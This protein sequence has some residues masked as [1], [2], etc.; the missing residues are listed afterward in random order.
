MYCFNLF[1]ALLIASTSLAC[2]AP[3]LMGLGSEETSL[4]LYY[5]TTTDVMAIEDAKS[6]VELSAICQ[7]P[8]A[9]TTDLMLGI[10]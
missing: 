6:P 8:L 4:Q 1:Y 2:Q 10:Q 7:L 9:T 3:R 5:F